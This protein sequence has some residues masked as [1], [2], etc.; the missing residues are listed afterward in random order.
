MSL[1][2]SSQAVPDAGVAN[3]RIPPLV[4]R[5]TIFF[6]LAQALQGSGSQ[7]VVALGAL[8][9]LR[10]TDSALFTGIAV[11]MLQISRLVVSYPLGKLADAYG[12]RPAML[13]GLICGMAGAPLLAYSMA[14][15]SFPLFILGTFIFGM[16]VGA[17]QQ[18]RV[19][20]SDMYPASRRGEALGYLL[21]GSLVG[22]I[23]APVLIS[24]GASISNRTGADALALPW[25]FMPLLIVPSM[26]I[27][28]AARPDP[29]QIASNLGLFWPGHAATAQRMGRGRMSYADFLRSRPRLTA[30]ACFAPAQGVMS[31][32]MATTPLVLTHY[33]HSVTSVSIAVTLHVL[34]MYMFS[35]PLGRLADKVGRSRLLWAGLAVEGAGALLVPV[36]QLYGIIT[37][38]IFLVGVGWSAVFVAA[39]ATIAD[40]SRAEERGRAIGVNDSLAAA[41]SIAL[42]VT[43]GAVAGSLGL[44]GVGIF[45]GILVALPLP[46]LARL[47]ELS[48]GR[49][50]VASPQSAA[51]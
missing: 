44:M 1:L 30:A 36:T 32:L 45:G 39:T 5:N 34:G 13:A 28:V 15:T 20:V 8:M 51:D 33:G 35:I 27:I 37:L 47:R 12:R 4:K 6:A 26:A 9:V 31:M 2:E 14:W 38:G 50:E 10:L 46:L 23:F 21:T 11:S 40:T 48:P 17:T 22:T 25:F 16:G 42:P 49:F 43:G 29:K 18:L 41:F 24:A 19:A 3:S 7:M